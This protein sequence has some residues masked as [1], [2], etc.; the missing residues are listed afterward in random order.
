M[1]VSKIQLKGQFV[2]RRDGGDPLPMQ[3]VRQLQAAIEA[4]RVVR[5]TR[6]PSTRLLARSLGVSRNTVL[7]AYDELASRGFVRGRRGAGMYVC[8]PAPV[9]GFD[10]KSVMREAQYPVRRVE[11]RDQDLNVIYISY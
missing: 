7:A 11:L 9:S 1:A 10:L 6:L 8:L 5:G 3:L 2:I 4:G